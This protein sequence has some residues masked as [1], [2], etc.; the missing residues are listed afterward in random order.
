MKNILPFFLFIISLSSSPDKSFSSLVFE[1]FD[2]IKKEVQEHPKLAIGLGVFAVGALVAIMYREK[3]KKYFF[4]NNKK[5]M[6]EFAINN[7]IGSDNEIKKNIEQINGEKLHESTIKQTNKKEF[8]KKFNFTNNKNNNSEEYES[9]LQDVLDR[10]KAL[11]NTI[12]EADKDNFLKNVIS[13]FQIYV[14]PLYSKSED[15]SFLRKN[16]QILK[17]DLNSQT[18][19]DG[20]DLIQNTLKKNFSRPLWKIFPYYLEFELFLKKVSSIN[21][22]SEE[23]VR[24][25]ALANEKSKELF[26]KVNNLFFSGNQFLLFLVQ[27]IFLDKSYF[28]DY[29]FFQLSSLIKN[30]ED[31]LYLDDCFTFD[32]QEVILDRLRKR[33]DAFKYRLNEIQIVNKFRMMGLDKNYIEGVLNNFRAAIAGESIEINKTITHET[34]IDKNFAGAQL[35]LFRVFYEEILKYNS[36]KKRYKKNIYKKKVNTLLNFGRNTGKKKNYLKNLTLSL[37]PSLGHLESLS[38]LD[39]IKEKNETRQKRDEKIALPDLQKS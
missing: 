19:Q 23:R 3:I 5:E 16:L 13:N 33:I 39:S 34:S 25:L 22:E 12:S 32:F 18:S 1:G 8:S 4:G 28:N 9:D 7:N 38:L 35:S 6:D 10:C 17:D 37:I 36:L 30:K 14:D 21:E 11:F 26:T 20:A 31:R 24:D 27:A 29:F 15:K 2:R